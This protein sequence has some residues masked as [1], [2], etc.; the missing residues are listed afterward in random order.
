MDATL[1]QI[2]SS[3]E[4]G[5]NSY[6]EKLGESNEKLK[7]ALALYDSL[8]AMAEKA[9]DMMDFYAKPENNQA[10]NDLSAV[11]PELAKEKPI[12]GVRTSPPATQVAAGYHIAYDQMPK[13][14]PATN[15][16]YERVFELE[17]QSENAA[18]FLRM[19]AEEQLF[20]KMSAVPLLSKQDS[21]RENAKKL[22]QPVMANYHEKMKAKLSSVQSTAELEYESNLEAEI[23]IYQNLWDMLFLNSTE[24]L[25]GNAIT[26]WMLTHS[27]DDREEVENSYRFITEFF[28]MDF[29]QLFKVPRVWDYFKNVLF[30]SVSSSLASKG[31]NSAE[32]M[33]EGFKS[34]LEECIKGKKPVD[35][36]PAQNRKL[37]LWGIPTGME[38]I[39]PAYRDNFK[40][41]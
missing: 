39:E 13:D 21:L 23:S 8:H 34:V 26:S 22:S 18:V 4:G 31:V 16:V 24:N 33:L 35:M 19:M 7:K 30:G 20:L 9:K 10:M 5:L 27:E 15:R 40:T 38:T 11:M 36:G 41:K 12:H 29:D 17:K 14:D 2:L 37:L 32:M 28:G 6:R 3:F 1:K 25:L